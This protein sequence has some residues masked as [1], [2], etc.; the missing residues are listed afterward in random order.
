MKDCYNQMDQIDNDIK[1]MLT[2]LERDV[3]Y[4][5]KSKSD[6]KGLSTYS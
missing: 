4:N 2:S 3:G 1:K 6:P 5:I